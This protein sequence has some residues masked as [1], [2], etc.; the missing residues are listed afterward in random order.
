VLDSTSQTATS[1]AVAVTVANSAPTATLTAPTQGAV[2]SLG[3]A[4]TLTG[5]V[6]AGS[7]GATVT[8]VQFLSGASIVATL[9][10]VALQNSYSTTW[11][12]SAAGNVS[13][14]VKVTDSNGNTTTSTAVTA[15][16]VSGLAVAVTAPANNSAA[17]VGTPVTVTASAAASPGAT[18]SRVTFFA[19]GTQIGAPVL[20]APFTVA[21]TPALAGAVNLT[22]TVLDSA[23]Q[24][25]TSTAVAVTVAN[26]APTATLTAPSQGAVVTVGV[27]VP[28]NTTVAAGSGGATVTQVQ[29]LSGASIVATLPGVPA[30]N[31][32]TTNWTPSAAGNFA[33]TVKVTDSNGGTG[34]SAAVNVAAVSSAPTVSL[35]A[36]TAGTV[37][38]VGAQTTLVANATAGPGLSV[39]KVE[40][41]QGATVVGTSLV[42]PYV[43]TWT[44]SAAGVTTLTA[45]VTDSLGTVVTSSQVNVSVLSSAVTLT[46]P[47]AGA[48]VSLNTPTTLTATATAIAPA[49]VAK[50]D[51]YA[52]STLV[53]TSTSA[54][55][56]VAWT[57]FTSGSTSLQARA[58][59]TN[60][61]QVS[62][63]TIAVT[64]SAGGPTV[65]LT[66]PVAGASALVGTT[67]SLSASASS[68][69]PATVAK[70]E[71]FAD[72]VLIGTKTSTP[73]TVT[74]TP[75]EAA[76]SLIT[77]KVTD[78]TG[79]TATSAATPFNAQ[80]L[81]SPT[82]SLA[83]TGGNNSVAVGSSRY[84]LATA[85]DDGAIT[86]VDF[87]VDG[88]VVGSA[89]KAPYTYLF[90]ASTPTGARAVTAVAYDNV[91]N[92]TTSNVVTLDVQSAVGQLPVV[93]IVQPSAG[94]YVAAGSTVAIS[95]N[96]S[97]ADGT[98]SAVTVFI[99]GTTGNGLGLAA[100]GAAS[101]TGTTW[102]TNWTPSG[103]G[104]VSIS[105]LAVDDKG[106]VVAAPP[107]MVNVTDSS[108]PVI[109]LSASPGTTTLPTR[110]TRNIL[111]SVA[112]AA[113]RAI[114]RVEFFVD[115]AKVSEDT[116]APYSFRYTAPAAA[117][118]SI[119]TARVTDNAGISRDAQ[120]QF[121]VVNAVGQGPAANLITPVN[122]FAVVPNTSINLAATAVASGGT[123]S[124]V[125]F[126]QN[127]SPVGNPITSPPYTSS[128]VPTLPGSYVFDAIAT[129]DRGNTKVSN[130]ST[131]TAAFGTPT[132]AITSPKADVTKPNN[133]VRVTPNIPLTISAAATAGSGASVLIVEFLVDDMQVGTRTSPSSGNSVSGT[134]SFPWTPDLTM[135]G[136]HVITTRV[137]DTNSVT[138]L[139][140][141]I[142]IN[143]A[144]VVGT[145]PSITIVAPGN[146]ATIQTLS[147]ANL[148][149]NSFA[150]GGTMLERE[151]FLNDASIGLAAREQSTNAYRIAYDFS[152][153][154]YSA[155]TLTHPAVI[156][157]RTM[158]SPRTAMATRRSRRPTR[159]SCRLRRV[160]RPRCN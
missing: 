50:V 95:G 130:S 27:P 96:V 55:F 19:N 75:S 108:A 61:T 102:S 100:N 123:I 68:G 6:A 101:I 24:T 4:V 129:D 107:V 40:F 139:S 157:S 41:L 93:G 22:A 127:G 31:T 115:G 34:T 79:A 62:S 28:L 73:Y 119:V 105:A 44:P 118:T 160:S 45:R 26:S 143:V 25:L 140:T 39:T 146:G 91:G 104:A 30:Q 29:F 133:A 109:F 21:W 32:Y 37:L 18:V 159:C 85:A 155:L 60:G 8:Q 43:V 52:N 86:R 114:L 57:P 94:S 135:L 156:R 63:S 125:Q 151:F 58:T 51:F 7:G 117:G 54:P 141:P 136:N 10:G 23:N 64:V 70:V 131:V 65:A 17:T 20:A 158:R 88:V 121:S 98:V 110:A 74:W 36:P 48:T 150:T 72:G 92:S 90:T 126:Y 11:T 99:G 1:T 78:S 113:G 82:V 153:V 97:D 71:F 5:T 66:S 144:T 80:P 42:S 134:Y 49:L 145:P 149:A 128:F 87:L 47:A 84:L 53:G 12:P 142:N 120:L 112:P 46:A 56:S 154:N 3:N 111:A 132:I 38:G 148:I 16:V 122:N 103:Y 2:L 13:L 89:L 116:T 138:A 147:T 9:P 35:I 15:T 76:M 137:T 81:G 69:A 59:D 106:N 67:V 33:L 83:V 124:S 77:A 14:T 152:T